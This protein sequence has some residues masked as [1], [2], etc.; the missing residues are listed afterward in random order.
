MGSSNHDGASSHGAA[1]VRLTT[2]GDELA[3]YVQVRGWCTCTGRTHL[4]TQ[5]GF[6]TARTSQASEVDRQHRVEGG[7]GERVHCRPISAKLNPPARDEL[8][9]P[10]PRMQNLARLT[11][12]LCLS[13]SAWSLARS[14]SDRSG[15][16]TAREE[17]NARRDA[18]ELDGA[19]DPRR[20]GDATA[21]AAERRSRIGERK[22]MWK[23]SMKRLW[24]GL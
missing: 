6:R 7:R 13:Y 24:G 18:D 14:S 17:E 19:T 22:D 20:E 21:R 23:E 4:Q 5:Q 3:T 2:A 16:R 15:L 11:S 1:W 12:T 9:L 10:S 8:V